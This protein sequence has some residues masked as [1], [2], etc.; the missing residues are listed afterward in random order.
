MARVQIPFV[1]QDDLGNALDGTARVYL[2]G[3]STNG[4]VFSGSS[5]G[6]PLAQPLTVV[7][8]KIVGW[9]EPGSYDVVAFAG[10]TTWT[11]SW[12]AVPFGSVAGGPAGGVL[13][14]NYP[15]PGFAVDMATQAELDAAGLQ[16]VTSATYT[17]P[18]PLA[19]NAQVQG[20]V[21]MYKGWRVWRVATNQAARVRLYASGAQQAGD[22]ARP[23]AVDPPDY[24]TI[25]ANPNHGC[26][27]EVITDAT[28]LDLQ[29][30]PNVIGR[31]SSGSNNI[32][33]T[34]DNLS[35]S[36]ATITV[37]IYYQRTEL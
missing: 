35:G 6:S 4:D 37:T 8:G 9:V 7:D 33:I 29:V 10:A 36:T 21:A 31:E 27:L 16:A 32:P 28:H 15:N 18:A 22:G 1:V 17:T 13:S 23:I 11:K 30:A 3:T 34:V 12:D 20:T 19:S 26:A 14:G 24:P 25:N 2:R 5:G